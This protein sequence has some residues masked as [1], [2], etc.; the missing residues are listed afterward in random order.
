MT[1]THRRTACGNP[2]LSPP[3]AMRG[4]PLMPARPYHGS[5]PH[6]VA[7]FPA[8]RSSCSTAEPSRGRAPASHVLPFSGGIAVP[9]CHPC[10]RA[11]A[12]WLPP[13]AVHPL[14]AHSA[15]ARSPAINTR[16]TVYDLVH[17]TM[18]CCNPSWQRATCAGRASRAP[19]AAP[20]DAE[21]PDTPARGA[22][23][24]TPR[25]RD[26]LVSFGERLSTRIFAAHLRARGVPARQHDAFAARFNL[27][28]SDDFG[29]AEVAYDA[30]LPAVRAA[31]APPP[32]EP[33]ALPIVTGFLGRGLSTG[34]PR[35]MVVSLSQ[36]QRRGCHVRGG[37]P[38]DLCV[39]YHQ[40]SQYC[41]RWQGRCAG[42]TQ[43]S[44]HIMLLLNRVPVQRILPHLLND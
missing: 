28:T 34:A 36:P 27:A 41:V 10:L 44:L 6:T 21:T 15:C 23:E 24:L 18:P 32:G 29:A 3:R 11:C 37:S 16:L 13:A 9:A 33:C 20:P 17:A 38:G 19:E 31:L 25:A 30:A 42:C 40:I 5:V 1:A 39:P 26:S 12:G 35:T 22:Q 2:V 7:V 43:G 4:R 14:T 8:R